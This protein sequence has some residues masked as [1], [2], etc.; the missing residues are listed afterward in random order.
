YHGGGANRSD[1]VRIGVNIT[2]ARAWLR[3]EENQYLSVPAEIARPLDDDLLRLMGYARG[4][5]ALVY[6]DDLR[7]PL[8]VLR[9]ETAGMGISARGD[10]GAGVSGRGRRPWPSG[11]RRCWRSRRAGRTVTTPPPAPPRPPPRVAGST[12]P[13][14]VSTARTRRASCRRAMP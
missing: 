14:P 4:A 7:D 12:S 5:Y 10:A 1:A 9:G 3:Q 11:W 13:P 6:V 8:A 2:Y